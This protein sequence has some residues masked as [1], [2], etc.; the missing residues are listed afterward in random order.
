MLYR[1]QWMWQNQLWI[2]INGFD[3]LKRH[4]IACRPKVPFNNFIF[5]KQPVTKYIPHSSFDFPR[6]MNS[7]VESPVWV[8]NYFKFLG[9]YRFDRSK[10][11][12]IRYQTLMICSVFSVGEFLFRNLSRN[13]WYWYRIYYTNGRCFWEY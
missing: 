7:K 2:L 3:L 13:I 10:A 6:T 12:T 8:F 1:Q 5:I 9:L 4:I 11:F